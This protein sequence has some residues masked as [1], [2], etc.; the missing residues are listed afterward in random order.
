MPYHSEM[1]GKRKPPNLKK[2]PKAQK[3]KKKGSK[4]I[5]DKEADKLQEHSDHHS[6]KHMAE[7]K[8]LMRNGMSFTMAHKRAMSKVG[9]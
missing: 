7:M 8:K 5:T 1:E 4:G 2:K 3:P 9:K 6:R